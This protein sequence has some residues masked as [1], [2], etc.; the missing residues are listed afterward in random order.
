VS[1]HLAIALINGMM[2]LMSSPNDSD[3]VL[4]DTLV[5]VAHMAWNV[6]GTIIAVA[7]ASHLA[8]DG[9]DANIARFFSKSGACLHQMKLPRSQMIQ[10]VSNVCCLYTD[11]IDVD[12][13]A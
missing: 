11:L 7:G 2:Q 5:S 9:H 12:S 10:G 1:K 8:A 4:I 13:I 3:P 6:D